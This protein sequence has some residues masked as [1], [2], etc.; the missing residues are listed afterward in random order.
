MGK[1]SLGD[2]NTEVVRR[3]FTKLIFFIANLSIY[4]V[5]GLTAFFISLYSNP[6][7]GQIPLE[8]GEMQNAAAN[9]PKR[10]RPG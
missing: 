3:S 7:S 2:H 8:S 10:L 4:S 1:T 6:L 9:Q 5:L